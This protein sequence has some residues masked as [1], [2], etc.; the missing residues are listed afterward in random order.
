MDPELDPS[1]F[2]S[3][4]LPQFEG[5]LDLL[6]HLIQKHEIDVLD[7]PI[8]FVTTK[9]LEMIELMR[10]LDLDI[11]AEYL[12]MAA[13]LAHIKS[14]MLLPSPP[15]D[16]GEASAEGDEGE[17]PRAELVRRL[18]EYQKYKAAAEELASR[19]VVGRDVFPRGAEVQVDE[20]GEAP[21][22]E[23]P[24]IALL[25]AFDKLLKK[26][27]LT[28]SHEVT[29]ERVSIAERI[30]EIVDRLRE[31]RTARFDEL[32][33]DAQTTLDLVVTFLALLEMTRLRMTRLYQ[34]GHEEPLHV[35][36]VLLDVAMKISEE[37]YA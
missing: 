22:A 16:E 35:T 8:S 13:T 20:L 12:L 32:F 26:R 17:D 18:L 7:I 5:P 31:R 37:D 19:G 30:N 23:L 3:I 6:L 33:D 10:L 25:E 4:D 29:A 28:I 27:K 14:R 11:A 9:Y 2:L 24:V 1:P 36:L 21:L 34:S 15:A